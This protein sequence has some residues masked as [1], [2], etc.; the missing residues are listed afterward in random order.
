MLAS[1]L[2]YM[3]VVA[4]ER[5]IRRHSLGQG[6]TRAPPAAAP[7]KTV[8]RPLQFRRRQLPRRRTP[9]LLRPMH[10]SHPLSRSYRAI[11]PTS[12]IYIFS[13]TRDLLSLKPAADYCTTLLEYYSFQMIFMENRKGRENF[14]E[15]EDVLQ[16]H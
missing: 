14:L 3:L 11:L 6:T 9:A 1:V 13:K 12:L 10:K 7:E 4:G 8:A 16:G 5:S 15:N 2:V